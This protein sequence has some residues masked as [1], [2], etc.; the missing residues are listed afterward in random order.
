MKQFGGFPAKTEYAGVP[1]VFFSTLLPE[2][3]DIGELK[4]T[5]HLFRILLQ[6]KGIPRFVTFSELAGDVAVISSL[7]GNG[8]SPEEALRRALGL[9]VKRGTFLHVSLDNNGKTE[10]IYLMNTAD[11]RRNVE[12]ILR[13]EIRLP[14]LVV[15]QPP[16]LTAIARP[17]IYTLYEQNIGLLTPMIAEELKE[18]EK[19]YPEKWLED[20]FKEAVNTNR[21]NWKFISKLLEQWATE[22]KTN[23]TYQRDIKAR[24]PDKFIKGKYGHLFKR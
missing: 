12:K 17:N 9:T 10:D 14:G 2:I 20:A 24:D 22:G 7:G 19:L 13:G 16:E 6:K 11:G 8:T 21:R 15:K 1:A 23:G 3:T 5:L 4:L 18:A